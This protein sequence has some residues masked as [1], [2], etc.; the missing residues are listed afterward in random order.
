M[1]EAEWLACEDPTPMLEFIRSKACSRRLRLFAVAC[2]RSGMNQTVPKWL[3]QLVNTLEGYADGIRDQTK[4]LSRYSKAVEQIGTDRG[5][6][7]IPPGVPGRFAALSRRQRN[8]HLEALVLACYPND[9][10]IA[11]RNL[12]LISDRTPK[13]N[14]LVSLHMA[15][16]RD[17]TGNP[18][19]LITADPTWLTSTVVALARQM[20]E[21]RDFS[22][23]PI[24][25]DALQDAGCENVDVLDHCRGDGP[26]VRGCW[27]VDLV[28]GKT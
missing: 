8:A 2:C 16:L 25:A 12:P 14:S 27:V 10:F 6:I 20:Y 17:V 24:L 15:F 11:A 3:R 22:S 21:S 4:L 1:T 18:F 5:A 19:R 28:L 13:P 9:P 7:E 26:H 23:M